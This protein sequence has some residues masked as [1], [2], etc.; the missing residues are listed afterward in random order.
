MG[1]SGDLEKAKQQAEKID[2]LINKISEKLRK[3]TIDEADTL[4]EFEK[5]LSKVDKLA[6]SLSR[7][8]EQIA[9][10]SYT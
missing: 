6:N 2:S 3:T 7:H 5:N 10:S 8:E 4:G 9:T 1:V